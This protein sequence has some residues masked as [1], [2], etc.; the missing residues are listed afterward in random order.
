MQSYDPRKSY[1]L[2]NLADPWQRY[3]NNAS[4]VNSSMQDM[5]A[6]NS[7]VSGTDVSK[8]LIRFDSIESLIQSLM[9]NWWLAG[10]PITIPRASRPASRVCLA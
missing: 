3:G 6:N 5:V 1:L 8:I 4:K 2:T 7:Y 9:H 10:A